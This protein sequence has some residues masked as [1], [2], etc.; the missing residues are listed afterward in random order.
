MD[1]T[2]YFLSMGTLVC[3]WLNEVGYAYCEGGIMAK[4]PRQYGVIYFA[5]SK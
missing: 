4:N 2:E 5:H 3:D 1:E